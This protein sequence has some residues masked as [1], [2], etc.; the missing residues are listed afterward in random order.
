MHITDALRLP[1]SLKSIKLDKVSE[2]FW[3]EVGKKR[4]KPTVSMMTL[5]KMHYLSMKKVIDKLFYGE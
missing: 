4:K 5:E 1:S 2:R 3:K